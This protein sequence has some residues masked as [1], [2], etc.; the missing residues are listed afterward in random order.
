MRKF[1]LFLFTLFLVS[2]VNLNAQNETFERTA[3]IPAANLIN[4]FGNFIAGVDFDGDGM[5]EIYAVNNNTIDSPDALIPRIYKY[6]WDGASWEMVWSAELSEIPLQNTWPALAY[7]DLDKDGRMEIWWAPINWTD[8]TSNP[9]PA[10]IVVFEYPGDGSDNMGVDLLGSFIPN[11]QWTITDQEMF[12]L[13]PHKFLITDFDGDGNDEL[14]FSDR[15]GTYHFGVVSVSEIPNDASGNEVW[16]LKAS[17][18]ND[19]VLTGT[20]AK[21]DFALLENRIVLIAANGKVFHVTYENATYTTHP[22][23]HGLMNE[24]S[25]FKSAVTL[26]INDD[27]TDEILVASW[28][29]PKVWLLQLD[30]D[31]LAATQVADVAE[32]GAIRLNGGDWG[33]VNAD[34]NI[35]YIFGS[36]YVAG[37]DPNAAIY[38][39][40]YTGGDITDS[41]NY[42]SSV[43]DFG[44][45]E[46]GGDMDAIRVANVDGD[47]ADEV[48]YTS[49]YPRGDPNDTPVD[50]V[51]LDIMYTPVS[52]KNE[53]PLAPEAFFMEQNYPNPFNPSTSIRFGLTT[54]A[55]VNLS[56]YDILGKEVMKVIIGETLNAGTYNVTIDARHL[57]SGNYIYT[58]T[59]GS[60]QVSKKMIL[61]K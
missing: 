8:A 56:I 38:R 7:G 41:A 23:Q 27:G 17:G 33:D 10:R 12:N 49:G 58:L 28:W 32:L 60:H 42:Q 48:L 3:Q 51:I 39:L 34:G 40:A 61:M 53:S 50:I 46:I 31:T 47:E 44:I 29:Q 35:D 57:A 36:R 5:P 54:Q 13:R 22:A 24:G 55:V 19:P 45:N 52:V 1:Y 14:I 2:L 26:D 4:G 9:N 11:A 43:I 16:T 20:G 25:S 18:F 6:E 21:W 37:T 59:A 15:A 30:G